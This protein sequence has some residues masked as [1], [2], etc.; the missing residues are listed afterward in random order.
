MTTGL[1]GS[2][3]TQVSEIMTNVVRVLA[4]T[5]K[6]PDTGDTEPIDGFG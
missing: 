1:P 6:I 4:I 5:K 2:A 3:G